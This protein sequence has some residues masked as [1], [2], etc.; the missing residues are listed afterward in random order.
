MPPQTASSLKRTYDETLALMIEARNYLAYKAPADSSRL[1][2]ELGLKASC[3]AF[4]VTSRL[5]QVMAWVLAQR[6][7]HAGEISL[8]EACSAQYRLSGESICRDATAA[9]L[10]LPL[11]LISLLSRSLA[12]YERIARLDEMAVERCAERRLH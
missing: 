3:E 11:G 7:V 9:D 1:P 2:A 4:R 6:A 12:L 10:P 5:T 8:E